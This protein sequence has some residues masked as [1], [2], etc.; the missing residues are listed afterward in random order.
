LA[1]QLAALPQAALLADRRSAIE[2]SPLDD[3]AEALRREG[4]GGYRAVVDEGIAG[5]ARF[6]AGAGRHGKPA[7][8]NGAG[9]P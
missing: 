5:A 6:T 3:M 1:A 2:N 4:A 8:G 7:G 9:Q